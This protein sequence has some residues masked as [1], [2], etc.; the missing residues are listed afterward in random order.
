MFT[1]MFVL[2]YTCFPIFLSIYCNVMFG[3]IKNEGE[4]ED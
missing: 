4:D 3:T 1:I 2:T